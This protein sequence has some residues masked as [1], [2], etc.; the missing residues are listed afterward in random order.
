MIEMTLSSRHRIRNSSPEY[1][2]RMSTSKSHY[3]GALYITTELEQWNANIALAQ[4]NLSPSA[5]HKPGNWLFYFRFE[6]VVSHASKQVLRYM[7]IF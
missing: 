3:S 1:I 7:V 6:V 4:V 5:D 2:Y